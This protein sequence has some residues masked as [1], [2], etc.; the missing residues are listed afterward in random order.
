VVIISILLFVCFL[1]GNIFLTLDLSLNYENVKPQLVSVVKNMYQTEFDITAV[2]QEKIPLMEIYCQNYSDYVFNEEGYTIVIPCDV[3]VQGSDAIVEKGVEDVIEEI[4]YKDYN[5]NFW[6]CFKETGSPFFLVSQKADNYWHSKLYFVLMVS[7]ILIILGF[8]LVEHRP[9]FIIILG[10]LL[11]AA[12][13]LFGRLD[14][15]FSMIDETFSDF[16]AI[17]FSKSGAIFVISLIVGIL[18]LALGIIFK[19]LRWEHKKKK[20]SKKDVQEI[21]SKEVSK[22]KKK[23]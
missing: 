23:K 20:F 3:V 15:I 19:F 11:I 5:C 8:L 10:A 14:W 12:A 18:A 9:N 7:I 13:F 16:G 1:V 21:V 17:F 6:N 4:Y 22:V 2:I